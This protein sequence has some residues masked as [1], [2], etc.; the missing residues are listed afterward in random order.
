MENK[1]KS[2]CEE[3]GSCF[4]D[5][6]EENNQLCI[7]NGEKIFRYDTAKELLSDW[8]ETLVYQH[9]SCNGED[10]CNWEYEIRFIYEDVIGKYPTGVRCYDG[11]KK[12]RYKAEG[13]ISDGRPHGKMVYL[14]TFDSIVDAVCSMWKHNGI[15]F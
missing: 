14:G 11:K 5:F 10:G 9:H 6:F 1:M 2:L 7:D 8:V 13:Y 15:P 12:K 3:I 4:G